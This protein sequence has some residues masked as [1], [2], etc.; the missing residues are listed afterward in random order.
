[1]E[2]FN[3]SLKLRSNSNLPDIF[4]KSFELFFSLGAIKKRNN[5]ITSG[6]NKIRNYINHEIINEEDI[7]LSIMNLIDFPGILIFLI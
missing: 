2:N 7:L 6:E 3:N 4:N 1:M 5:Y